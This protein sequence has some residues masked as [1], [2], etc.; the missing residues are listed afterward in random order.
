MRTGIP[1]IRS[2]GS[3]TI[4]VTNQ[5]IAFPVSGTASSGLISAGG[6]IKVF[7]FENS[8]TGTSLNNSNWITKIAMA[9]DKFIVDELEMWFVPSVAFTTS[10]MNAMYFD[11][12]PSRTTPPAT[13]A[14]VSGDMHATSKQVYAEM[15]LKVLKN[16]LNRLPQYETFSSGTDTGVATV[17]SINFVHDSILLANSTA[18]GNIDLGKVWMRYKIR[19]LNPSS[20]VA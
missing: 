12:D 10:G 6:T 1:D 11:S 3:G 5:E 14:G 7:R 17:G 8:A 16:Q 9:Y 4:S 18:S 13:V 20:S 2:Q 19:F 15:R